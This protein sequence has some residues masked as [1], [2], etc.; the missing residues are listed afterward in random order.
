MEFAK[1]EKVSEFFIVSRRCISMINEQ[2]GNNFLKV[3]RTMQINK[4]SFVTEFGD[5]YSIPHT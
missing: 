3:K 5:H 1:T 4:Y 2:R